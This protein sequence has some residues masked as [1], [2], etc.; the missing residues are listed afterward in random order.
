[1]EDAAV[2]RPASSAVGDASETAVPIQMRVCPRIDDIG[3]G[4]WSSM[5][6]AHGSYYLGHPW[7]RCKEGEALTAES[8]YFAATDGQTAL[9]G[10]PA[11]VIRDPATYFFFNIRELFL[12]ERTLATLTARLDADRARELREAAAVLSQDGFARPPWLVSAAPWGYTSALLRSAEAPPA[13][14]SKAAEAVLRAFED[15]GAAVGANVLAFPYVPKGVDRR[16]ERQL[17]DSGYHAVP[18]ELDCTLPVRWRSFG[19]YLDAM[20]SDRRGAVRKEIRRFEQAGLELAFGDA[21]DITP[22]LADLAAQTS[23]KYGHRPNPE[24]LARE[25]D[26]WRRHLGPYIRV[27]LARKGAKNVGFLVLHEWRG[28]FFAK[29]AGFDYCDS[30]PSTFSYFNVLFYGPL[31]L[32]IDEGI[33]EI[34]YGPGGVE[35]RVARLCETRLLQSYLRFPGARDPELLRAFRRVVELTALA[36]AEPGAGVVYSAEVAR[37]VAPP[38][39]ERE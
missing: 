14:R 37:S 6:P 34:H 22:D 1:V 9:A 36:R 7:L 32:A 10:L 3:E 5:A 23:V 12:G 8:L 20:S 11:Y 18:I 17:T 39:R 31:R 19:D 27:V 16:F 21:A 30:G 33:R 29:E 2:V 15:R 35:T 13:L 26:V 4:V 25:F 24:R 28:R 38:G